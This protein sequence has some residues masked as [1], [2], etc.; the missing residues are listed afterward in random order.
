VVLDFLLNAFVRRVERRIDMRIVKV[1]ALH[2]R[3]ADV[4]RMCD[5]VFFHICSRDLE[6]R[7]TEELY[8]FS[9][10]CSAP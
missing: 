4:F 7:H 6:P 1:L 9:S 8:A 2:V 5:P 10:V 3:R